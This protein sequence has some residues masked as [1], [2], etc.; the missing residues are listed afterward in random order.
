MTFGDRFTLIDLLDP[1]TVAARTAAVNLCRLALA[2]VP[3]STRTLVAGIGEASSTMVFASGD[4]PVAFWTVDHEDASRAT[5]RAAAERLDR[6]AGIARVRAAALTSVENARLS[7]FRG[8]GCAVV[9]ASRVARAIVS[10][11]SDG[12][13]VAALDQVSAAASQLV[14]RSIETRVRG[15]PGDWVRAFAVGAAILEAVMIDVEADAVRAPVAGA[16]PEPRDDDAGAFLSAVA[17]R[18]RAARS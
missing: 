12:G 17:A 2:G 6:A 4:R 16:R 7:A 10:M 15:F 13:D 1:A 5:L 11:A 9:G 18:A 14:A 8:L 3:A